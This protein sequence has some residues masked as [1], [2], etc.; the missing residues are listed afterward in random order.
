MSITDFLARSGVGAFYK[1]RERMGINDCILTDIQIIGPFNSQA[2]AENYD[3]N[4]KAPAFR[5]L[6]PDRVH[7]DEEAVLYHLFAPKASDGQKS[8]WVKDLYIQTV[9]T[10]SNT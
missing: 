9:E 3:H 6:T 4:Y 7:K 8:A 2:Q 1:R 5:N 10:P